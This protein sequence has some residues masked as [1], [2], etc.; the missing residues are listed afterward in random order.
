LHPGSAEHIVTMKNLELHRSGPSVWDTRRGPMRWDVERWI[1]SM[2]A[3]GLF[4]AAVRKRS[5]ASGAM[6]CA[7]SA[8]AWWALTGPDIRSRRRGQLRA[9]LQYR[10]P[11]TDPVLEASEESFPASDAPAWTQTTAAPATKT[12]RED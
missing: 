4:V 5:A 6:M 12:D 7:A 10:R 1:A 2:V 8:L 11:D 3:G 9:V